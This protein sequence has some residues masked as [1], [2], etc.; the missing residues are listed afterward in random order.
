MN[1]IYTKYYLCMDIMAY[2]IDEFT[3]KSVIALI[4]G[5]NL[6]GAFLLDKYFV[7]WFN[8]IKNKAVNI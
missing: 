1:E 3:I 8:A 6:V 4:T 2:C 5:F 7:T